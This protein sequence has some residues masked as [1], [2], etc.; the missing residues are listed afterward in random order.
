MIARD[1]PPAGRGWLG[2]A[3]LRCC[4]VTPRAIIHSERA[5]CVRVCAFACHLPPVSAICHMYARALFAMCALPWHV[6]CGTAQQWCVPTA[7]VTYVCGICVCACVC[8]CRPCSCK[9]NVFA[10]CACKPCHPQ[11]CTRCAPHDTLRCLCFKF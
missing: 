9:N 10:K 5:N 4:A 1:K 6:F 8:V 2:K 7:R 11:T 3:R